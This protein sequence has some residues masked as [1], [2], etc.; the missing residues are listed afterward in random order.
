MVYGQ[1][2]DDRVGIQNI[3]IP[4]YIQKKHKYMQNVLI[5]DACLGGKH[6]VLM[7]DSDCLYVFGDNSNHQISNRYEKEILR[8]LRLE[9]SELGIHKSEKIVKIIADACNTY[10]IVESFAKP[11]TKTAKYIL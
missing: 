10:I 1:C 7:G 9:K 2:G 8:P 3:V 5:L 4:I 6:T 11:F